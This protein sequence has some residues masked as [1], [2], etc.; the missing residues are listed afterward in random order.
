MKDLNAASLKDV[1]EWFQSYYGPNN[2]VIVI[3]GDVN[4][5]EV[6]EKVLSL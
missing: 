5:Q 2:A 4:P 1:H 3:A 6:L